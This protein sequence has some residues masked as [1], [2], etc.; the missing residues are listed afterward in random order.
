MAV[1][2]WTPGS[3]I[4]LNDGVW[5][6]DLPFVNNDSFGSVYR[7]YSGVSPYSVSNVIIRHSEEPA[8]A[9]KEK[10]FRHN[11]VYTF[12]WPG[13]GVVPDKL[14]SSS[15]TFHTPADV[16]PALQSQI[17]K[18]LTSLLDVSAVRSQLL[19]WRI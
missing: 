17:L 15:M 19:A 16:D 2:S 13:L 9:L 5:D 12:K 14:Y 10:A 11:M 8:T 1:P 7:F 3:T 6:Q 18:G 4:H